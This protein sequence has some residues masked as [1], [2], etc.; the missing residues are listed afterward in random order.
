[1]GNKPKP[2][3]FKETKL[4]Q[5]L[6]FSS[7]K[8]GGI[9][10]SIDLS[11]TFKRDQN[12]KP[13]G[14]FI[15]AREGNDTTA[16]AERIIQC[17]DD[18]LDTLLF[19]SGM[20][21]MGAILDALET[22]DHIILQETIYYAILRYIEYTCPRR[23]ITVSKISTDNLYDVEKL[24]IEGKTKFLWVETPSNPHWISV[25]ISNLSKTTSALGVKLI[26]DATCS[27]GCTSSTLS[28]G[29]DICFQST[30][31][32]LNGHSDSLG[33]ALSTKKIDEFWDKITIARN[34][35]GSIMSPFSAWLLIRGL[36]TLFIRFEKSSHNAQK[37]AKKLSLNQLIDNVLYPGL[38][39]HP[40]FSIA[41]KQMVNGFGGMVSIKLKGGLEA[42]K[43]LTKRTKVFMQATSLGSVESLIEHRKLIEGKESKVE[44]NLVRLS[45]GIESY[46]DLINDLEQAIKF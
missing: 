36:K 41:K 39:D 38:E 12:Y 6:H 11:T 40:T 22:G 16:E 23:G 46:E 29:A 18:S 27:P 3:L 2:E 4:A 20:S 13:I 21:A 32:Y 14:N 34:Y 9:I 30:T 42:A 7:K 37:I 25:D 1:M 33:G 31:K 43:Q 24:I 19:S 44:D 8:N 28:L 5:S 15:Y 35:Q 45:I 26:V 10:P 17:L